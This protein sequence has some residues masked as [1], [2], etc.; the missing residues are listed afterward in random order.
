MIESSI[1]SRLRAVIYSFHMPIFMAIS[2]YLYYFEVRRAADK[3]SD[4]YGKFVLKKAKR[5]LVPFVIA[6]Y[7]WRKP[8]FFLADTKVYEEMTATQII[9]SYLSVS[10]TGALW[11]L[12]VLFAIFVAQRIFVNIIWK[13]DRTVFVWLFVFALL[14]VGLVYFSGPIHHV[15]LYNYYFF[16]GS[17]IHRYQDKFKMSQKK[18]LIS[19]GVISLI[20]TAGL[21]AMTLPE[22][23]GSIYNMVLATA[24]I[25]FAI[26]ISDKA[27]NVAVK[28]IRPISDWSMG[29]YLFHEP[30]I[31]AVGSKLPEMGV[32]LVLSFSIIGLGLSILMTILLR[33]IGLRFVMGE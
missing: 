20:G 28:V 29:I 23:L 3:K 19:T 5:L 25:I 12:Y 26:L 14:N 7:L 30:L 4:G 31:V 17:F 27:K 1:G 9:K 2:G 18:W 16:L 8:L 24:D 6:L 33:K 32:L 15:M 13:S 21:L 22:V 10:T 11:F